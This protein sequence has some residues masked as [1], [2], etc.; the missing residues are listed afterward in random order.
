MQLKH[1][2]LIEVP[3]IG[4][5]ENPHRA[6]PGP[7]FLLSRIKQMTFSKPRI[8][9]L[10]VTSRASVIPD[11]TSA[12]TFV[13]GKGSTDEGLRPGCEFYLVGDKLYRRLTWV[14]MGVKGKE[15]GFKAVRN[16][17]L[18]YYVV[19]VEMTEVVRAAIGEAL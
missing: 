19:E 7:H 14:D 13:A 2:R 17:R 8:S 1:L 15:C 16:K 3:E 6:L 11:V 9:N 5:V 18:T 10:Y 4:D 12:V